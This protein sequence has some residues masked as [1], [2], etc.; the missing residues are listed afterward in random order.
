[1]AELYLSTFQLVLKCSLISS[2]DTR[3]NF[4]LVEFV[5]EGYAGNF[6]FSA[7]GKII[8]KRLR[9]LVLSRTVFESADEDCLLRTNMEIYCPCTV[10]PEMR[11]SSPHAASWLE[12][13]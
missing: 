6:A 4:S 9:T 7:E 11:S 13:I 1:M 8:R 12:V 10:A 3:N 5:Q 2:R